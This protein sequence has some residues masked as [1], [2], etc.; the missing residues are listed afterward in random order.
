MHQRRFVLQP[1]N[2]I[3]PDATHP[4][5]KKTIAQLLEELDD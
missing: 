4:L 1:L 3:A 5:L 2:E